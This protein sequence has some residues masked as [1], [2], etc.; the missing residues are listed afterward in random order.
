[1]LNQGTCKFQRSS[2]VASMQGGR[3]VSLQRIPEALFSRLLSASVLA[4]P[5]AGFEEQAHS[6]S[7]HLR[8]RIP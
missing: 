7:K 3:S 5:S 4:R 6:G 8:F 2:A 1:M